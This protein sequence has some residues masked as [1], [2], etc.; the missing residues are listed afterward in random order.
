MRGLGEVEPLA[1]ESTHRLEAQPF[2]PRKHAPECL[3]RTHGVRL[4]FRV[5]KLAEEK[6]HL[7]VPWHPPSGCQVEPDHR[8]RKAVL[9]AGDGRVVVHRIGHVPAKHN[10]AETEATV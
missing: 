2:R 6:W 4:A 1:L 3:A 10:V 5:N 8:V 7:V 9:P